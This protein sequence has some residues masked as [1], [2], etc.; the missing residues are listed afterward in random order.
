[1]AKGWVNYGPNIFPSLEQ[2]VAAIELDAWAN[3]MHDL[4]RQDSLIYSLFKNSEPHV[5]LYRKWGVPNG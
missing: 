5:I 3:T 4:I 2:F 1:M